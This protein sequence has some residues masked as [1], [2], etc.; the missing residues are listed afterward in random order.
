MFANRHKQLIYMVDDMFE[1]SFFK[2]DLKLA[3]R[4]TLMQK[5]FFQIKNIFLC[6]TKMS[7]TIFCY[8]LNF[9]EI[10]I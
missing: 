4:G 5:R 6:K 3:V 2:K 7:F 1:M 9:K 10:S 8:F